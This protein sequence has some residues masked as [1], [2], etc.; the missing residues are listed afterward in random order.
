LKPNQGF[1]G[2][3]KKGVFIVLRGKVFVFERFFLVGSGVFADDTFLMILF[4]FCLVVLVVVSG[5][6]RFSSF[7]C[8]VAFRV[9]RKVPLI[10][11]VFAFDF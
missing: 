5:A 4:Y 2:F 11:V 3:A 6:H 10:F 7:G 8:V 1:L 9:W